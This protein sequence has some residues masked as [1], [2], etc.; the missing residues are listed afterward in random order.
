MVTVDP[1]DGGAALRSPVVCPSAIERANRTLQRM[2]HGLDVPDV[3][4]AL[5]QDSWQSLRDTGQGRGLR[6]VEEDRAVGAAGLSPGSGYVE[7]HPP[8]ADRFGPRQTC[9]RTAR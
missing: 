6:G 4:S 7:P 8:G 3:R 2:L 1:V 9:E 5:P